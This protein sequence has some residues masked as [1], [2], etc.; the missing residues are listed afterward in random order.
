VV[1]A[2]IGSE[3]AEGEAVGED[4]AEGSGLIANI[5]KIG[6]GK[7]LEGMFAGLLQGK[8]SKLLGVGHGHRS[9]E[10]AVDYAESRSVDGNAEGKGDDGERGEPG[11]IAKSTDGVA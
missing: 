9:Q 1:A 2:V 10:E 8:N 11:G 7:F 4:I 6:I 3:S 5:E